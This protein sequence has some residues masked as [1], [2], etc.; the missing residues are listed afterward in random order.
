M[1]SRKQNRLQAALVATLLVA[2]WIPSSLAAQTAAAPPAVPLDPVACPI[3]PASGKVSLDW[4]PAFDHESVVDG[5]ERFSLIFTTVAVDLVTPLRSGGPGLYAV[6]SISVAPLSNG[7]YQIEFQIPR[8]PPGNYRVVNAAV[9]P[10]LASGYRGAAP[11]M[12]FSPARDRFCIT[13]L[14][15]PRAQSS[16]SPPEEP[17]PAGSNGLASPAAIT[18]LASLFIH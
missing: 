13:V 14:P 16:S 11:K 9:V 6:R 17:A 8:L 4:N 2:G 12:T 10:R 3:V 18:G 15:N 7:Y 1:N 5:I